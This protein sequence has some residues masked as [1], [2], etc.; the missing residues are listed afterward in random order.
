M[1]NSAANQEAWLEFGEELC[2][3]SIYSP[4]IAWERSLIW[5]HPTHPLH[6]T[7]YAQSPLKPV[8]PEDLRDMLS[9]AILFLSVPRLQVRVT[10]SYEMILQELLATLDI[11]G[12]T[13]DRIIIPALKQQL[14]SILSRFSEVHVVHSN[15][16]FKESL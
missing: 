6:Q 16:A 12:S 4:S 1:Q 3:L 14:P 15:L 7:C 10:E 2:Q 5:G 13:A 8:E 11:P 9:P